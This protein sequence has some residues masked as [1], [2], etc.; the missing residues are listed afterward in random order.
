[1]LDVINKRFRNRFIALVSLT[2][3]S[4]L[5]ISAVS[6]YSITDKGLGETYAQKINTITKFR[7]TLLRDTLL[8]FIPPA[9]IAVIFVIIAI[10]LYT[11]RIVGPLE[12]IKAV[13]QQISEGD[14]GILIKFREKDAIQP[15]AGALN[16][17]SSKYK[18]EF[19][20]LGEIFDE[21]SKDAKDL[22]QALEAGNPGS[23]EAKRAALG[24][25][26]EEIRHILAKIKL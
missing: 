23:V 3:I 21:M 24:K 11:H 6:F 17:L 25:K 18:G 16:K 8:I 22:L 2:L 7:A 1:M 20:K 19:F 14:P 10:V 13:T 12:R 26:A 4:A 15:L 9:V 5:L